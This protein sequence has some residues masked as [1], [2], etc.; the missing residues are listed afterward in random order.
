MKSQRNKKYLYDHKF[1]KGIKI[2]VHTAIEQAYKVFDY[3]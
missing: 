3:E 2:N 1:V